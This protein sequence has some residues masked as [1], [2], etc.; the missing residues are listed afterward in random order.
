M[1]PKVFKK[2]LGDIFVQRA[3]ALD[4]LEQPQ[5]MWLFWWMLM[6]FRKKKKIHDEIVSWSDEFSYT[7]A[8]QGLQ[9]D[10]FPVTQQ[11]IDKTEAPHHMAYPHPECLLCIPFTHLHPMYSSDKSCMKYFFQ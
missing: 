1:Y 5:N 10:W 9:A 4:Y 11:R 6:F 3:N 8:C 7:V 2:G